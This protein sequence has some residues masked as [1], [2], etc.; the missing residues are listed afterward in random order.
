M[1]PTRSERGEMLGT[2]VIVSIIIAF[3]LFIISVHFIDVIYTFVKKHGPPSEAVTGAVFVGLYLFLW[4]GYRLWRE[5]FQKRQMLENIISALEPDVLLVVDVD[6]TIRFCAGAAPRMFGYAPD[7]LIGKKTDILYGDRREDSSK[8]YEIHAI[9]EKEG[10]HIG[11]ADGIKKDGGKVALEILTSKLGGREGAVLLLRDISARRKAEDALRESEEKHR[12]LFE[13]SL[14][15]LSLVRGGKIIDVNP[16]WLRLH[17]YA[18]KD[19]VMGMDVVN[20]VHPDDRE[21]FERRRKE[22]N[23]HKGRFF[24]IRD[25][26]KNGSVAHVQLY[27][28]S[29]VIGGEE[30]IL[31]TVRNVTELKRA[32]EALRTSH[33]LLTITNRQAEINPMIEY[34]ALEIKRFT[35]CNAV[36]IRALDKAGNMAYEAHLGPDHAF[37]T[38]KEVF[39]HPGVCICGAV[40]KGE[41]DPKQPHFTGGGSFLINNATAFFE[42]LPAAEKAAMRPT[43]QSAG[44][45]SMAL[46]PIQVEGEILGVIHV[47]D[48]AT[49]ALPMWKVKV[50]EDAALELGM[51]I[52]RTRK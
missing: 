46:V 24:E 45:Q 52:R 33:R 8:P 17:G 21:T 50:L 13:G 25:V 10:Y 34:F 14:E 31:T 38:P 28:S 7:E 51:A 41:T 36:A 32:D 48:A 12:L 43:C 26:R 42:K 18:S 49:E 39:A 6:R 11:S 1:K 40:L 23:G 27:S 47:A 44:H 16:S 29:I 35:G 30:T 2:V 3:S 9:L 20:I 15:A 37:C 4:L 19:D 5:S 22:W